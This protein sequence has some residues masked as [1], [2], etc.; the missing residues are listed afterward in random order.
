MKL[1]SDIE[2]LRKLSNLSLS[3]LAKSADVST[4]AMSK[5]FQGKS[6]VSYTTFV[7]V[8]E[9]LGISIGDNVMRKLREETGLIDADQNDLTNDIG[10]LFENLNDIN[11]KIVLT[12]LLKPLANSKEKEVLE[13][14][15]RIKK[16]V[17][18]L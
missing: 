5:F 3:S 12:S 13:S 18:V 15:K 8:L 11:K 17:S 2:K 10:T 7:C 6:K 16:R 14:Y 4:A 1:I 9:D